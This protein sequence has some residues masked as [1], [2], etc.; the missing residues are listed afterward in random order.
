[1]TTIV[2]F[3]VQRLVQCQY[4]ANDTDQLVEL[5]MYWLVQRIQ[6]VAVSDIVQSLACTQLVTLEHDGII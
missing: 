6:H 1:M 3:S 4:S 2:C 5:Q